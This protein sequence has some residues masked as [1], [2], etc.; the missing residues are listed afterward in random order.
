MDDDSFDREVRRRQLAKRL[1]AHQARTQTICEM[2]HLT[3]HQ[4]STL[5]RRWGVPQ[6]TRIRGPAPT[7]FA[8]F[9]SSARARDTAA[10]LAILYR[11]LGPEIGKGRSNRSSG[12]LAE[13]E[14]LCDV[15]EMARLC[16]PTADF[17]FEQIQLLAKGL[18]Q[19]DR[20]ALDACETCGAVILM[21]LLSIQFRQCSFCKRDNRLGVTKAFE[22]DGSDS[23]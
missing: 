15:A 13:N 22:P 14:R 1:T 23:D 21:D 17:E 3:R 4:L 10:G 11:L 5:R 19:G 18:A 16:F 20:I 7:S 9:L 12:S 6:D 8:S 2:T